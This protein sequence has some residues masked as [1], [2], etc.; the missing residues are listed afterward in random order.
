MAVRESVVYPHDCMTDLKLQ[1]TTQHH[2]KALFC[3]S[4]AWEEVKIQ[5]TIVKSKPCKS[6][7]LK[8]GPSIEGKWRGEV[9]P[10]SHG[11]WGVN[12]SPLAG[13]MGLKSRREVPG[14]WSKLRSAKK[15]EEVESIGVRQPMEVGNVGKRG[16]VCWRVRVGRENRKE[17]SREIFVKPGPPQ[18]WRCSFLWYIWE[19]ACVR[20]GWPS[21]AV[22]SPEPLSAHLGQLTLPLFPWT[23]GSCSP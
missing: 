22:C 15:E 21:I 12:S 1:P 17:S 8:A 19:R 2:E 10:W 11:V 6:D 18:P 13:N 3:L 4:L 7:H 9:E 23:S 5:S 14:L 16:Q 20:C